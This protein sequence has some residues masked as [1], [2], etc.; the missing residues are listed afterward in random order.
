MDTPYQWT[1][2]VASHWGGTRNGTIVHWPSG[3]KARGELRTQFHH[4]IDVAPTVLEAAGLPHPTTVDGVEQHPIEGTSMRYSF[5]GAT[6]ADRHERQYFEMFCNRG[7]YDQGWTAVTRH[8]IP[9]VTAG[10]L[11]AFDDD[12]WELYEPG[13]WSQAHDVAAEQPEKLAELKQLW[14]DEARKYNVLPLDDR[15]IERFNAELVGRPLLVRGNSQLLFGGMG[16]LTE[17]SLLNTKNKSHAVTAEIEVP[18]TG[19]EGVILAQGGA[20]AGWSLYTKAGRPK[21]CYN[22]L[23][24]QHFTVEGDET[25]PTGTHQVRMEFAYDGGGLAKGGTVTLYLDGAKVGEGRVE[26]TVPMIFSGDETADVGRDTGSPVSDD[27][28]VEGSVFTGTVK[29]VQ[30]DLGEDAEDA[31]HLITPEERLH[32]AMARQ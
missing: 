13:D 20:F 4:V 14:L 10:Q 22:L 2:Q 19:A 16:R 28:D 12:V 21:Y 11:P 3:I 5:D 9:W 17:S 26:A 32:V 31:D 23:G 29:W 1:K 18:E 25:V 27:Y 8:S 24:L 30:I 15:R 6:E 7:I